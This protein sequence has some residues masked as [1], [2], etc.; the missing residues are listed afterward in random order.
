[1]RWVS[2]VVYRGEMV[3]VSRFLDSFSNAEWNVAVR[4]RKNRYDFDVGDLRMK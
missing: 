1:M 4:Y 2:R 3:E